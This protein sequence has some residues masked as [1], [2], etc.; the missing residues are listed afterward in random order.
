MKK[1]KMYGIIFVILSLTLVCGSNT[2]EAVN[3]MA[4]YISTPPFLSGG[5]VTPNLL[6]LIDNSA[7]MYDLAY[8]D[9]QRYCYGDDYNPALTYVGYFQPATWYVYNLAAQRFE[10]K[11]AAEAS[12]VWGSAKYKHSDLGVN[13]DATPSVTAFAAKG[14]FLNWAAASKLDVEKEVL[15]GGKYDV[16]NGRLV[17]ES[18]GCVGRRF[19]KKVPVFDPMFNTVL[20]DPGGATT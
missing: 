11:T 16:A 8:V 1:L 17:M 3:T 2:V 9:D 13:V 19:V 6:L 5:G 7:S 4:D 15:T 18:R 12:L 20:P 10:P 14:N